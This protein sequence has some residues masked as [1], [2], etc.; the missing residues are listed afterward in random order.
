MVGGVRDCLP[1]TWNIKVRYKRTWICKRERGHLFG[2]CYIRIQ[3]SLKIV[4][5]FEWMCLHFSYITA[6]QTLM[7]S[8][9]MRSSS[10]LLNQGRHDENWEG[11]DGQL[12]L[13][14]FF[15]I[16]FLFTLGKVIKTVCNWTFCFNILY[17][18]LLL[19][20]WGKCR[21]PTLWKGCM[22][23]GVCLLFSF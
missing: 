18:L 3:S 16:F 13:L 17:V 4:G 23:K 2:C 5:P 6:D 11:L 1:W 12:P 15:F 21:Y 8:R 20:R 7:A 22:D 10:S 14:L 19:E 9:V